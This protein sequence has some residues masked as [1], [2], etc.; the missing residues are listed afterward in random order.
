MPPSS[1]ATTCRK[2]GGPLESGTV[3]G[4]A[5]GFGTPAT[6]GWNGHQLARIP[7]FQ[8]HPSPKFPGLICR[9]CRLVEFEYP[10][11]SKVP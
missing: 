1:P 11:N 8:I 5:A 10:A 2:C 4:L 6:V 3:T 7:V 9:A